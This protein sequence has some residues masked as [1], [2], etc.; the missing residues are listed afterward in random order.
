[1]PKIE[2]ITGW[3]AD[4]GVWLCICVALHGLIPI[5]LRFLFIKY[6]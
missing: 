2:I 3:K 6:A 5:N 1:L 4:V